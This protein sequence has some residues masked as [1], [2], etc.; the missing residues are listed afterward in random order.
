[1]RTI[2][3]APSSMGDAQGVGRWKRRALC[4]FHCGPVNTTHGSMPN[5]GP[6]GINGD[7][8]KPSWHRGEWASPLAETTMIDG[9]SPVSPAAERMRRYRERRRRGPSCVKVQLR[10]SEVDALSACGLLQPV[11]RQD[12]NAFGQRSIGI[13]MQTLLRDADRD[14]QRQKWDASSARPGGKREPVLCR[15]YSVS[16]NA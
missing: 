13:S 15:G 3:R 11:E 2:C 10:R 8:K 9:V 14:A 6:L 4:S 5:A 1:M 12:R 16:Q 7:R